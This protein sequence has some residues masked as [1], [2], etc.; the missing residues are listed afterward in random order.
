[1]VCKI[2]HDDGEELTIPRFLCRQC[3]P[4]LGRPSSAPR[5][6]PLVCTAAV[7]DEDAELERQAAAAKLAD[8]AKRKRIRKLSNEIDRMNEKLALIRGR[9]SPALVA[10]LQAAIQS[11]HQELRKAGG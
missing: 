2:N 11:A 5:P 6:A 4:D 3:N 8:K 10:K 9:E 7:E 1:M